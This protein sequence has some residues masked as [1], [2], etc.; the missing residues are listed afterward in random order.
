M[1]KINYN[2]RDYQ[3]S[4]TNNIKG[5]FNREKHNKFAAVVLPTG[6]GKSFV[7]IE[8]ILSMNNENYKE[9]SRTGE[10]NPAKIIYVAPNHEILSQIQ[11]HIVKNVILGIPNLGNMSVKEINDM[12]ETDFPEIKFSGIE[13]ILDNS[14]ASEKKNAIIKQIKPEEITKLVKKAFPGL[15]FKCYAGVKDKKQSENEIPTDADLIILDEAHRVGA[16]TWSV[17]VEKLIKSN[18]NSKVLAITATPERTD[19][20]GENMMAGIAKMVYPDDIVLEDTYMAKEV[21]VLDAMRDGIVTTPEI[22]EFNTSLAESKEYKEVL[23]K[24]EKARGTEKEKLGKILDEMEAI[25]GYSPRKDEGESIRDQIIRQN[26]SRNLRN[27]NGK[28]IAFIPSKSEGEDAA[29]HF[30][31]WKK[32]VEDYF[33]DVLDENGNPVSVN[34]ELVTSEKA[35]QSANENAKALKNFE[36]SSTTHGGIKILLAIDKL[37]EGVHVDG[38]DGCLMFRNIGENSS[39]LFLQQSGRCI[40]SVDPSK[41][42]DEQSQTQIFDVCGNFLKQINNETGKKISL[43]YDLEKIKEISEWIK[44]EGRIPDPNSKDLKEARYAISL[45]R[46][47]DNYNGKKTLKDREKT[48]EIIKL[49]DKINLWE[50]DIPLRTEEPTEEELTGAKFLSRTK[51]QQKFMELYSESKSLGR[52]KK[53]PSNIRIKK[54][55][56]ILTVLKTH[57]PDLELPLGIMVDDERT[58]ATTKDCTHIMLEEFLEANFDK[59]EI[60]KIFIELQDY[61]KLGATTKREIYHPGEQYDLAEELAFVR[62]KL[63]TSQDDYEKTGTDSIFKNYE[64]EELI[65]LNIIDTEHINEMIK[66]L[67]EIFGATNIIDVETGFINSEFKLNKDKRLIGKGLGL[68]EEFADYSIK[69]VTKFFNGRDKE[70]YDRDGYDKFGYDRDGFNEDGIHK[71]T[72][73]E[74]DERFFVKRERI[75]SDT[76]EKEYYW[77]NKRTGTEYDLLG[78][79]HF[80]VDKDGFERSKH[81]GYF[82]LWHKKK[83]DGTYEKKGRRVSEETGLDARG[84]RYVGN[85]KWGYFGE[86]GK[87]NTNYDGFWSNGA[88][89]QHPDPNSTED[90]YSR[91]G[92]DIDGFNE[93]GFKK[94]KHN[95]KE[96]YI[97]RDTSAPYNIY[98]QIY[99]EEPNKRTGKHLI[100]NPYIG[101]AKVTIRLLIGENKTIDEVYESYAKN[102]RCTIEEAKIRL[103]KT[104]ETAI[105]ISRVATHAF[106]DQV[107][108]FENI[109][110]N[111]EKAEAIKRFFTICPAAKEKLIQD[112]ERII[113][114]IEILDLEM[115]KS[116]EESPEY[117]TRQDRKDKLQKEYNR[118]NEIKNMIDER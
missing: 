75:N 97:H 89:T 36:D 46:I 4:A 47:R 74:Y 55:I 62:G 82:R 79:D 57:K 11:L 31:E 93:E 7:A 58:Q 114:D 116:K 91:K 8:Q 25:I 101:D 98:G 94:V 6:G 66:E 107:K 38:I 59:E 17:E 52:A 10:I 109:E 61:D 41:S 51:N 71:I 19:E 90:Y 49:G 65:K 12:L 27:P 81:L 16:E 67:E 108:A 102:K 35:V 103:G 14:S 9:K 3:K 2:L 106:D 53:E 99:S 56:N 96:I 37:N 69:T 28:Y 118:L 29:K 105:T 88:T 63:W 70:G 24:Y 42:F 112:C 115:E 64:F 39:T 21:Y 54:L 117:R 76:G 80:G 113:K 43:T 26:I 104:L 20:K 73:R 92:L 110:G 77:E 86:S 85:S 95:D 34:I 87:F 30:E 40:S 18:E 84:F 78:F 5:I 44:S 100:N 45:R 72:G 48:E 13:G 22:I 83:D 111:A 68:I 50:L 32:K 15:Q 33:K 60:E 23:E 1:G